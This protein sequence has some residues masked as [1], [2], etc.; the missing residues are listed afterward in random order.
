ME[1]VIVDEPIAIV[2]RDRDQPKTSTRRAHRASRA[3]KR[4]GL[5]ANSCIFK[6]RDFNVKDGNDIAMMLKECET[7]SYRETQALFNKLE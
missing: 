7:S 2:S 1:Q 3:T 4:F 6:D 5:W